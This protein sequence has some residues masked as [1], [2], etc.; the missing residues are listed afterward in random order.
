M[1]V[2]LFRGGD[3]RKAFTKLGSDVVPLLRNVP[4]MLFTATAPP[5]KQTELVQI[6]KLRDP[7]KIVENPD[8]PNITF[9]VKERAASVN[10]L[11]DLDILLTDIGKELLEKKTDYPLTVVYT[12]T[13]V[14]SYAYRFLEN[15]M[16]KEQY[17]GEN[18]P[19]NRLF[20]QYHQQYTDK[21]KKFIVSELCKED[22]TIRFVLATVCL[23]MGLN[24]PNIR[25]V[26]HFKPPTS[27]EKYYQEIGRAGR[28]GEPAQATL[29]Y[30]NSDVRSNR[31]GIT[32]DMIRY[33]KQNTDCRR[34][35]M[36]SYFGHEMAVKHP[37]CCDICDCQ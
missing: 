2:L 10:T 1:F 13:A 37:K 29:Y 26:I 27:L 19:E 5:K 25:H 33:C 9:T 32:K 14:I 21:M 3:F 15:M 31:P 16:G 20:A 4:I 24:A 23:G 17:S 18:C 12:D 28:N 30:N 35:L 8:R 6:M 11:D 7:V 22:S 34:K 36:L